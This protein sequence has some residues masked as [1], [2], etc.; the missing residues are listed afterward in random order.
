MVGSVDDGILFET[1][2]P[3]TDP[4]SADAFECAAELL[5]FL[6]CT[7][8]AAGIAAPQLGFARRAYA[9]RSK[10]DGIIVVWN[11]EL[12]LRGSK[13]IESERCLSLKREYRTLRHTQVGVTGLDVAG[14]P[15]SINARGFEARVHQ[16]E[17]DHLNGKLIGTA[18]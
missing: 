4:T 1:Q 18:W 14:E 8:F 10:R 6:G 7:P 16:H 17:V 3:E 2:E 11:P 13:R 9:Y 5:K 12:T 15:L